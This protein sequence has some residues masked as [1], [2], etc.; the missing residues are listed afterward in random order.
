ME[1]VPYS[2]LSKGT[3]LL[4]SPDIDAG[5]FFRT[6]IIL[7]EHTPNG[8][9]GIII[10]KP[11]EVQLPEDLLNLERQANPHVAIRAGGPVQPNQMML[12]HSADFIAQQALK[13][14]DG[15]YLGGDLQFLQEALANPSGPFVHLCFGYTGWPAGQLERE[16]LNGNWFLH[17]GSSRLVFET[18]ADKMWQTIL[19]EMGG[20]Y[21]TLSMIPEDLSLN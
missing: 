18:P 4:A 14:C 10:N 12:V 2:N 3:L 1:Q 11:L 6:V 17:P 7:C 5:I 15:V 13:L 16:F 19:R 20:K 21:A 8:S 9:F